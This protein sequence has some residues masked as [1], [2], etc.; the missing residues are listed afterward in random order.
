M[1]QIQS[2]TKGTAFAPKHRNISGAITF[3]LLKRS[4]DTLR[5]VRAIVLRTSG[6]EWITV[7]TAPSF[8]ILTAIK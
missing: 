5:A 6:H 2:S 3:E 4:V 7:Y 1:L 8:S